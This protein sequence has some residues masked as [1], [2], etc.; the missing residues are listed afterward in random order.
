MDEDRQIALSG[1]NDLRPLEH[2]NLLRFALCAPL[3]QHTRLSDICPFERP[4]Q[5]RRSLEA[6]EGVD[7]I[8]ALVSR[9]HRG[10]SV[11]VVSMS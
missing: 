4:P 9:C 3:F 5:G 6:P 8:D 11:R 10:S 7:D 1:L 2:R